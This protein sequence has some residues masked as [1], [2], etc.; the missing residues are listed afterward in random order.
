MATTVTRVTVKV[1]E[2]M[3]M[4]NSGQSSSCWVL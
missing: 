3:N 4:L 2:L 1:E